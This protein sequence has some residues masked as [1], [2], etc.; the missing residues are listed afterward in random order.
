MKDLKKKR[1]AHLDHY[2]HQPHH[3]NLNTWVVVVV[4]LHKHKVVVIA[5]LLLSLN[6]EE[7]DD[8]E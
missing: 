8:K 1:K 4:V 2:L 6:K 5:G 3:L 7:E